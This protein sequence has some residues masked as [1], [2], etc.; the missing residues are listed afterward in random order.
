MSDSTEGRD[1]LRMQRGDFT[2]RSKT[3]QDALFLVDEPDACGT[4][5]LDGLGFGAALWA[6]QRDRPATSTEA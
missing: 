1:W 3:S 6:D 2:G 5:T 4:E